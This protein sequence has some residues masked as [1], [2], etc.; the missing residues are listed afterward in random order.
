MWV[1]LAHPGSTNS[2]GV[3]K[4]EAAAIEQLFDRLWKFEKRVARELH[5]QTRDQALRDNAAAEVEPFREPGK[6]QLLA[7]GGSLGATGLQMSVSQNRS[8]ALSA[9]PELEQVLNW[10]AADSSFDKGRESA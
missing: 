9:E 5:Q 6:R 8:A 10:F 1:C 3:I 4:I 2:S 7:G